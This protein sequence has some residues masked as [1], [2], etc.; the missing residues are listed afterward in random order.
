[1]NSKKKNQI[2]NFFVSLITIVIGLY[3][4]QLY[5][6]IKNLKTENYYEIKKK[7]MIIKLKLIQEIEYN[8]F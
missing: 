5:L 8:L 6:Q 3:S 2:I 1:M 4:I 7:K